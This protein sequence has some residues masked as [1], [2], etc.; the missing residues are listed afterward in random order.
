MSAT[1]LTHKTR[2]LP[3]TVGTAVAS[4][5]AM[6]MGDM[7]AGIVHVDGVTASHTLAVYGSSDGTTFVPLYGFDGQP[8]TVSV[9]AVSGSVVLPDTAYPLRFVKLVSGTDL[10]TAASVVIS[11]KS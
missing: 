4:S 11:L 5:T 9:N 2:N 6:L 3:V 8:A 1:T 7:A 10:G